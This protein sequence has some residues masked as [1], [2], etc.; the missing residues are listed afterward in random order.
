LFDDVG[1][2]LSYVADW[3]NC[4]IGLLLIALLDVGV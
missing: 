3:V 4:P 2:A 1:N